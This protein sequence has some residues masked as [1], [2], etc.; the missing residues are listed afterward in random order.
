MNKDIYEIALECKIFAEQQI[1]I[2]R[3]VI[4]NGH[5]IYTDYTVCGNI[6]GYEQKLLC[7]K[8]AMKEKYPDLCFQMQEHMDK[9]KDV[10]NK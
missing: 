10:S 8:D 4:P 2:I 7:L 1:E 9:Y 3:T 5:I 6:S